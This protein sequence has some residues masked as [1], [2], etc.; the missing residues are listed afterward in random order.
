VTA[1]QRFIRLVT[2]AV[3]RQPALWPL[4]KSVVRRE[5]DRLAPE[6]DG[7]R[8]PDTLA[9]LEAA[10]DALADAPR[11]VLD[12]GTGTGAVA[13]AVLVR[14]PD[15]DVT[16]VDVAPRMIEQ[17]RR[18]VPGA[19]FAVADAEEL[20]FE[21]AAFDLVTLGN[22]IPFFDEL[23]RVTA[24]GGRVVVAFSS[25]EE[26]PIYVPQETLRRELSGRGFSDFADFSA[27][28]GTAFLARKQ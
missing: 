16:G 26:T 5:F 8:R 23:A 18:N 21:D 13:Q 14:F 15:A 25:G 2:N 28:R 19:R 27:G 12:L 1:G 4:F 22:M 11:R 3:V 20:P 10:L 6:W 17:A 7:L 9:P 24:P